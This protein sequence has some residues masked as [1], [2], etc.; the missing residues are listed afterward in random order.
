[1]IESDIR[2]INGNDFKGVDLL[3]EFLATIHDAGKQLGSDDERDLFPEALH[4]IEQVQPEAALLENVP[5]FA[6][7]K[8]ALLILPVLSVKNSG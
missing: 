1:V 7:A 4:L 5:G 3:V 2:A 6:S 8:F